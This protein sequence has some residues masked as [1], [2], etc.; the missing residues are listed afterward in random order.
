VV[1]A[2][3][4]E[5]VRSALQAGTDPL[6]RAA[7]LVREAFNV[8]RASVARID[9]DEG[10][11]EIAAEAGGKLLA[12][13]TTLPLQTCSY[14]AAATSGRVFGETDFDSSDCFRRPID[15]VIIATGYRSGCS[16]PIRRD[17]HTIG[18]LSLS[19]SKRRAEMAVL[20]CELESV[21]AALTTG[22]SAATRSLASE[23]LV[24]SADLV[25]GHGIAQMVGGKAGGQARIASTLSEAILRASEAAPG[26][27]ICDDSLD[28]RPVDLIARELRAA[29][30]DAPLMVL[31]SRKTPEG[32][33]AAWR[34]GAA[35]HLSHSE[36]F[37]QL[38][39]ALVAVRRG[40][41][42]IDASASDPG[43]RLTARELELLQL[44]E[45]AA[46]FKQIA[47]RLGIS[48]ATAKTHGRNLFRK[49][50]V[51]S[52]AEAVHHARAQG[53]LD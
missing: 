27:L 22:L 31:S 4:T 29:G 38:P 39:S 41:R 37:A 13:G 12:P 9:E 44:L 18:A 5:R 16:A 32:L 51:S 17:G 33:R 26:V 40:E 11:F 20:A 14:F 1:S 34:A 3:L 24:C 23:V 47:A 35:A 21:A 42:L 10:V 8:D 49:L 50:G 6:E 30:I 36:A 46:R 53:L 7:A 43:V 48:E 19:S 52:R 25:V 15:E 28:G 2:A 45:E